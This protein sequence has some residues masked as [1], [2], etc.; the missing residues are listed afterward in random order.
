M[1]RYYKFLDRYCYVSLNK[2]EG[3]H[4]DLIILDELQNITENNS[5]FFSQNTSD[6]VLG[7]SATPPSDEIKK[8]LVKLHCPVIYEYNLLF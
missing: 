6:R 1:T 7:L 2:I 8:V 3:N 5:K 4:Y